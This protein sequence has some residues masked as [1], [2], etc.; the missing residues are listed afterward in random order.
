M[1]TNMWMLFLHFLYNVSR[2]QKQILVLVPKNYLSRVL[3]HYIISIYNFY[4]MGG[5]VYMCFCLVL[6]LYLLKTVLNKQ[7]QG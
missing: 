5:Q 2:T 4:T 7:I 6:V 1:N 3:G